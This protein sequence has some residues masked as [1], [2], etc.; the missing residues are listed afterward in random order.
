MESYGLEMNDL[1]DNHDISQELDDYE[2]PNDMDNADSSQA[3]GGADSTQNEGRF[4]I[5]PTG[6]CNPVF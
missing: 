2:A 4:A 5:K 3:E 1:F 6:S